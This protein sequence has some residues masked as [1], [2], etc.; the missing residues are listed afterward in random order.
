MTNTLKFA[1]LSTLVLGTVGT[2]FG[3]SALTPTAA[4]SAAPT[5]STVRVAAV[6]AELSSPYDTMLAQMIGVLAK[7]VPAAVELRA[8]DTLA[9][10]AMRGFAALVKA[11]RALK[12]ENA[13]NATALA[14]AGR[15]LE[16]L[17]AQ[18]SRLTAERATLTAQNQGLIRAHD[19]QS[20]LAARR[21][22]ELEE[23]RASSQAA[24]EQAAEALHAAQAELVQ[25]RAQARDA[26]DARGELVGL[27]AED[28]GV[29]GA[30][31]LPGAP[32]LGAAAAGVVGAEEPRADA[33]ADPLAPGG[34]VLAEPVAEVNGAG[35]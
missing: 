5:A 4:A 15:E 9:K 35:V 24:A 13:R 12:L 32:A 33:G 34:A 29:A 21:L 18:I 31:A 22:A 23:L 20:E 16:A 2:T 8:D 7:D 27:L 26:A 1:L 10:Q 3:S 11:Y 17:N 19:E 28:A 6:T 14:E 25:V 30:A